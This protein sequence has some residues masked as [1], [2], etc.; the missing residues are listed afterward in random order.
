MVILGGS[1]GCS[2]ESPGIKKQLKFLK[3]FFNAFTSLRSVK[4]PAGHWFHVVI[5]WIDIKS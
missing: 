2:L 3:I 4:M 1:I 5:V